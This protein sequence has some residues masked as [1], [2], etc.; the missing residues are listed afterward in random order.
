MENGGI[1]KVH[2]IDYKSSSI[3]GLFSTH[4]I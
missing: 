4:T 3:L 1:K 2:H